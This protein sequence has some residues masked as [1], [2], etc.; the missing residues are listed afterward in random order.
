MKRGKRRNINYIV[1]FI[2]SLI[3]LSGIIVF[4]VLSSKQTDSKRAEN[5]TTNDS[6]QT[7]EVLTLDVLDS[8]ETENS[9]DPENESGEASVPVEEEMIPDVTEDKSEESDEENLDSRVEDIVQNMGIK[10]K[11]YQMFIVMPEQLTGVSGVTAAGEK[12]KDSL[13]EKPVGGIIYMSGNLQDPDQ[14]R[15]MI[16]NIQDFADEIEG[17]PL[18]ICIDEEGGRVTRIAKNEAFQIKNVGPMSEVTNEE[19]A[20]ECGNYIG[21]Y[22][23]QYGFNVDFAPDVD[24]LTNADNTIIGD[25]SFGSEAD[26]VSAF[27][28]A[29]S[30]GLHA[31]GVMSTFKHFPGHGATKD[32]T[33][34]GYAY[35]DKSYDEMLENELRPFRDAEEYQIDFI[36]VSH[37]SVPQ[38]IGD[39][40]PCS[41]SKEMVTSV[42]REEFGYS[43]II[44]TDALNMG[45]ISEKYG[46][47]TAAIEAVKAG[48]DILLVP[49]DFNAAYNSVLSAVEKGEISE[50]RIDDSVRRIVMAK[51]KLV[52]GNEEV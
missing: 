15:E 42:L 7:N 13:K 1:P 20:Y 32:D 41:L 28:K 25:R 50:D 33:H 38:I 52:Q 24:V 26:V 16:N 23:S 47:G 21:S 27:G 18:F 44:V 4:G 6:E 3:V 37:I 5:N 43:G 11:I 51:M 36:M 8:I 12:T 29:Y 19:D 10:E 2:I 48:V 40:T 14:T 31:N 9:M 34:E 22:L 45:A 17:L 46:S 39:N 35:T 49:K 30:E